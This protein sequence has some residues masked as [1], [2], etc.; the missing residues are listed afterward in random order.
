MYL[1]LALGQIGLDLLVEFVELAAD[2][3]DLLRRQP[4]QRVLAR[5]RSTTCPLVRFPFS[6]MPLPSVPPFSPC[7]WWLEIDL[8]VGPSGALMH[9]RITSPL[10]AR[11]PPRCGGHARVPARAPPTQVWQIP[12]RQP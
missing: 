3:L 11:I 12:S 6:V 7:R 1:A 4:V 5:V 10:L 9:V 2:R 8:E